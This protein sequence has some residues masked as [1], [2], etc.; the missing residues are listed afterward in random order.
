MFR[1]IDDD[2]IDIDVVDIPTGVVND[3]YNFESTIVIVKA[4]ITTEFQHLTHAA[5][6]DPN[7]DINETDLALAI[8]T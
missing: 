6:I 7:H 2:A 5:T 4:H 3:D 8:P 1:H